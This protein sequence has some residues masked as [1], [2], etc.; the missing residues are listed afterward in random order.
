MALTRR[1]FLRRTPPPSA[2]LLIPTTLP[3]STARA[4]P[5]TE[6]L[7]E[8]Y[9]P[10]VADPAGLLDLPAGFRYRALSTALEGTESDLRFTQRLTNGELVPALHDGMAAFAGPPGITV[11]VRNHEVSPTQL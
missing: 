8:G 2:A 1:Q 11:L 3:L 7:A 5:A 10:L 6:V 4:A 9:G